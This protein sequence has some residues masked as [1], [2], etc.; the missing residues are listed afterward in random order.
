[1]QKAAGFTLTEL[2]IVMA[3]VAILVSIATPGFGA[4]TRANRVLVATNELT[5]LL[6]YARSEALTRGLNVSVE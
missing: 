3:L 2:L 5:N 4:L 1:M 6:T